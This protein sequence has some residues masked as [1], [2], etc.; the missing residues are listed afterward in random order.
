MHRITRLFGSVFF[1]DITRLNKVLYLRSIL[2]EPQNICTSKSSL[3]Y[4]SGRGIFRSQTTC[5]KLCHVH[6]VTCW[7]CSYSYQ[8]SVNGETLFFCPFCG[9]VQE[10]HTDRTYFDIMNW[11]VCLGICYICSLVFWVQFFSKKR[12]QCSTDM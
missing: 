12:L 7:K 6:K 10:A 9:V 11:C 2:F 8:D 3:G 1:K 4:F 5:R